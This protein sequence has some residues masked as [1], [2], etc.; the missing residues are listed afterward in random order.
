[1]PFP[2]RAV[3]LALKAHRMKNMGGVSPVASKK[4][5]HI[6]RKQ[7]YPQNI[8]EML[9]FKKGDKVCREIVEMSFCHDSV[10]FVMSSCKARIQRGH[11]WRVVQ[12]EGGH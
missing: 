2:D 7:K 4:L 6:L 12:S 10:K 1:M 8:E 9:P 11:V 3:L 5:R